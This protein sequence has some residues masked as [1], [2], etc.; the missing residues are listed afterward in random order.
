MSNKDIK[1]NIK[2]LKEK[3]IKLIVNYINFNAFTL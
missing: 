1:N 3:T 2:K